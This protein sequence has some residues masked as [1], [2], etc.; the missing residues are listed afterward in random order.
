MYVTRTSADWFGPSHG[1][2]FF[3]PGNSQIARDTATH[4]CPSRA[5][6]NARN[7]HVQFRGIPKYSLVYGDEEARLDG[8]LTDD[9]ILGEMPIWQHHGISSLVGSGQEV[10]NLLSTASHV[11]KSMKHM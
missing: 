4:S 5:L 3:N 6:C 8:S 10:T 2:G 9:R 11:T 7:D 1:P